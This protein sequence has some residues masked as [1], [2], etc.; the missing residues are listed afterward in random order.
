MSN[1]RRN[2]IEQLQGSNFLEG[3]FSSRDNVRAPIQIRRES[4][5][6]HLKR[7]I[8]VKKA[9]GFLDGCGKF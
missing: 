2:F 7:V 9:Q 8:L 1:R 5:P 3:S 6:Q 4:Q